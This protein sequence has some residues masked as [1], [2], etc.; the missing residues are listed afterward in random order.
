[1][2]LEFLAQRI[3]IP[4]LITYQRPSFISRLSEPQELIHKESYLAKI[5]AYKYF[6]PP[7]GHYEI[8][9]NDQGLERRLMLQKLQKAEKTVIYLRL[10]FSI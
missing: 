9:V 5:I 6:S 7:S 10:L 1:M 2:T 4:L 8:Q 3:L